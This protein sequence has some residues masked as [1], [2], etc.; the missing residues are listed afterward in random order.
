MQKVLKPEN[1]HICINARSRKPANK[2]VQVVND[3][4]M[5]RAS[6]EGKASA[7]KLSGGL[8]MLRVPVTLPAGL[9][10]GPVPQQGPEMSSNKM[11]GHRW[12]T[13]DEAMPAQLVV[14]SFSCQSRAEGGEGNRSC[15]QRG[16]GDLTGNLGQLRSG[17]MK[18]LGETQQ[19]L[20]GGSH[21]SQISQVTKCGEQSN[22]L[23]MEQ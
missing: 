8:R 16:S 23:V 12:H 9:Y 1:K 5:N 21:A 22:V 6:R 15:S 11:R 13:W 7:E 17:S 4:G 14:P 20:A 3:G 10:Q 19:H 18:H 2:L